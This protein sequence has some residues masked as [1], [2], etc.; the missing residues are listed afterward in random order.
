MTAR[1]VFLIVLG[2]VV[3][4]VRGQEKARPLVLAGAKVLDAAGESL[5]EGQDILVIDGRIARIAPARDLKPPEDAVRLDLSGLTLL[6]GLM[7]IH[8]HL[9]LHPY[10]EATWDDQVLKESLEL[11]TVRAVTAARA[12]VEAGFTTLRDLGTEGAGYADVALRDAIARGMVPGPRVFASTRAIVATSCYGP[13]GFDPRWDVPKGAQEATGVDGV[14]R[15]VREQIAAGADWVKFYADYRRRAGDP[16]TPTFSQEELNALVAE[17]HSAGKPVAAHATTDEGIRRAV[18]A[19]VNSIEHGTSASDEALALMHERGVALCPTLA[20]S[21][22]MARY[23]GWKPGEALPQRLQEA[24]DM[25]ARAL[26]SGVTIACG[27]D[28]GVFA[29]GD[30]AREIELMVAYGMSPAEALRAATSTAAQVLGRE[31]TLGRIAPGYIADLIAVRGDPLKDPTALR[32]PLVVLKEG[33]IVLDRL[34]ANGQAARTQ[35]GGG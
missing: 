17:A 2:L 28:V 18:L 3:P 20:A 31:N 15:A 5:L 11:R 7:D 33:Q 13:A 34:G 6:P 14:R 35:Q 12:T 26:R 30:N 25:F 23:A 16:A 24:R 10:D 32:K 4:S 29:H 27:S 22:A 19:G 21:E 8:S 1:V 9:L